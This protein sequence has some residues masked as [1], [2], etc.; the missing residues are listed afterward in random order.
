M[1][2][3]HDLGRALVGVSERAI[4]WIDRLIDR[5]RQEN[6]GGTGY[7]GREPRQSRIKAWRELETLWAVRPVRFFAA[8]RY[9][10]LC[11]SLVALCVAAALLSSLATL[12]SSRLHSLACSL[13]CLVRGSSVCLVVWLIASGCAASV[14][15]GAFYR[16]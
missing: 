5:S 16:Q 8:A 6:E 1:E 13:A 4:E 14:C 11:L 9:L 3:R 7:G 10:S 2:Q 15:E 12:C